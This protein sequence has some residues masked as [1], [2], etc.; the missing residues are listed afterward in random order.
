MM[1]NRTGCKNL[2]SAILLEAKSD[3]EF[4]Q[5]LRPE[6]QSFL[7]SDR[8]DLFVALAGWNP[9]VIRREIMG[10]DCRTCKNRYKEHLCIK[11]YETDPSKTHNYY[12][13]DDRKD[14]KELR[15][16]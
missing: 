4:H 9:G 3:Y 15:R 7:F 10:K 12:E 5:G 6:I 2:A 8:F 1:L 11:C 14:K 13:Y 16:K